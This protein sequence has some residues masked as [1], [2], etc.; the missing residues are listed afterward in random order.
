MSIC[1]TMLY[2]LF[3]KYKYI[4]IVI[5]NSKILCSCELAACNSTWHFLWRSNSLLRQYIWTCQ[6]R[7]ESKLLLSLLLLLG[8]RPSPDKTFPSFSMRGSP[9]FST[10]SWP[11]LLVDCLDNPTQRSLQTQTALHPPV[12][13]HLIQG[14]TSCF[15]EARKLLA[16]L[17]Q[18]CRKCLPRNVVL[19]RAR[20]VVH[21]FSAESHQTPDVWWGRE[22]FR[23]YVRG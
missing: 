3:P 5:L 13:V 2:K 17:S 7:T 6:S 11:A 23:R 4:F 21:E 10:P 16:S 18:R 15:P 8:F 19:S 9:D 1:K 22:V 20:E 14:G 12:R